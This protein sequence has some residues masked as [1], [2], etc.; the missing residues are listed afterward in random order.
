MT[1]LTVGQMEERRLT[2]CMMFR[3]DEKVRE[4]LA[5]HPSL[6][7][8]YFMDTD[9]EDGSVMAYKSYAEVGYVLLCKGPDTE[10]I[11]T[12]EDDLRDDLVDVVLAGRNYDALTDTELDTLIDEECKKYEPFWEE[13]ILVWLQA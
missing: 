10:K 8:I 9:G 12:S 1:Q 13:C 5:A 4:T 7:I 3:A 6:P 11:Y 2:A